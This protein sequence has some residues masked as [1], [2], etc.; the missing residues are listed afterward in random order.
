[1]AKEEARN[2]IVMLSVYSSYL[3]GAN[4]ISKEGMLSGSS[5]SFRE[6]FDLLYSAET[7]IQ[8][9]ENLN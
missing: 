8:E 4:G 6:A 5:S 9:A 1:M 2:C 3:V 7:M